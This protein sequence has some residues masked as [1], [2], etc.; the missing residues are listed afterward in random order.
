MEPLSATTRRAMSLR[1]I[2]LASFTGTCKTVRSTA[3]TARATLQVSALGSRAVGLGVA[4]AVVAALWSDK[5]W[6]VTI[7]VASR[8]ARDRTSSSTERR[9]SVTP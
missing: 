7:I 1:A 8:S 5:C 6:S 4:R 9:M 3:T 2:G